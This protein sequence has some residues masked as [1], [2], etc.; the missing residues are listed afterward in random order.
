MKTFKLACFDLLVQAEFKLIMINEENQD[1]VSK[2]KKTFGIPLVGTKAMGHFW[3]HLKRF[4]IPDAKL[5][6]FFFS[7]FMY[8]KRIGRG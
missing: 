4:Q 3:P 8:N 6:V 7:F 1:P 5:H 2:P